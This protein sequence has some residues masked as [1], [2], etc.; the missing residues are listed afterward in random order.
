MSTMFPNGA[1]IEQL[2]HPA[3]AA[4]LAQPRSQLS[5]TDE[6]PS[7]LA[8]DEAA[9]TPLL[10]QL[11]EDIFADIDYRTMVDPRFT[12]SRALG[13]EPSLSSSERRWTLIALAVLALS[14]AALVRASSSEA[15]GKR[16][17]ADETGAQ[18]Q[19]A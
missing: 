14:V 19:P 10:R 12:A 9:S 17:E 13:L 8:L 7:P 15:E 18:K 16:T 1:L 5:R 3:A 2:L 4:Q 11:G 6:R